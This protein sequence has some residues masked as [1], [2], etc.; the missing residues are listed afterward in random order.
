MNCGLDLHRGSESE[1]TVA[2][3]ESAFASCTFLRP[4]VLQ[5]SESGAC[6][7]PFGLRHLADVGLRRDQSPTRATLKQEEA[8]RFPMA[9]VRKIS[10]AH[11]RH[12]R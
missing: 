8:H 7:R 6:S 12:G 11:W 9:R 4:A 3:H 5:S 10:L 2:E 1:V